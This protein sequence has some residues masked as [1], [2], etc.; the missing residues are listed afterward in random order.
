MLNREIKLKGEI[1]LH[2]IKLIFHL[3]SITDIIVLFEGIEI[4][5]NY[6]PL[7]KQI[8]DKNKI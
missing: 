4:G 3:S 7:W 1:V 5:I 6:K 2:F 8:I